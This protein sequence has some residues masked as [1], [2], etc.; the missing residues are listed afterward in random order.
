MRKLSHGKIE[1]QGVSPPEGQTARGDKK[2][3]VNPLG[4]DKVSREAC[5][6]TFICLTPNSPF[7]F[8][9]GVSLNI[10][11]FILTFILCPGFVLF[12]SRYFSPF[13]TTQNHLLSIHKALFTETCLTYIH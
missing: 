4:P 3:V 6:L 13:D 11:S 10:H 5:F 1:K 9:A 7:Y 8:C 2:L 12:L